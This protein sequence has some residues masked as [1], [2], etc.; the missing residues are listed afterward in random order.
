[1]LLGHVTRQ[2]LVHSVREEYQRVVQEID[3]ENAS[4]VNWPKL[5]TL[6]LPIFTEKA[7]GEGIGDCTLQ[8]NAGVPLEGDSFDGRYAAD[9]VL[10]ENTAGLKAAA[11]ELHEDN[12][13]SGT[14]AQQDIPSIDPVDVGAVP[15][16][17]KHLLESLPSE[18]PRERESLVD[19]QTQLAM[20]LLWLKQAIASRQD[21]SGSWYLIGPPPPQ[22]VSNRAGN[23]LRF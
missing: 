4:C 16:S 21:V 17:Y 22:L 12:E 14:P 5:N 15:E 18:L 13:D 2:R 6:C 7:L 11:T 23:R 19:L 3:A 20:E 9:E 8:D 10:S 1:M